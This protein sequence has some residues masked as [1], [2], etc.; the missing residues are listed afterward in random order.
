MYQQLIISYN[1]IN[2]T[3]TYIKYNNAKTNH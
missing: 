1:A 3:T 2:D